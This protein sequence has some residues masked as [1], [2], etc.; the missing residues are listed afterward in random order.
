MVL[1]GAKYNF[2]LNALE[3]C[4]HNGFRAPYHRHQIRCGDNALLLWHGILTVLRAGTS[5][6]VDENTHEPILSILTLIVETAAKL[7]RDGHNVVLV[8][9]GAV[10]VG[11]RRM[12]VDERPKHL[13][14][15]QVCASFEVPKIYD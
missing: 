15:I 14:R 6:I 5:S 9:S 7:H 8:S 2:D 4:T 13:P 12:D 1:Y 10:G 3:I 11:L